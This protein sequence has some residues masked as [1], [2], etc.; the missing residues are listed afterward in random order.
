MIICQRQYRETSKMPGK[1]APANKSIVEI[2]FDG[3]FPWSNCD[4]L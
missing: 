3:I 1:I 2:G 4:W